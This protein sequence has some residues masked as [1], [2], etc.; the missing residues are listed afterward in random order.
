MNHLLPKISR[1]ENAIEKY[2]VDSDGL[3]YSFLDKATLK[4]PTEELF[5]DADQAENLPGFTLSELYC[6]ENVGMCTGG[7]ILGQLCHYEVTGTPTALERA[8][9]GFYGLY[10]VFR[11]GEQLEFGFFPKIYG[12][13]FSPETST[14]QVLYALYAMDKFHDFAT[15]EERQMIRMMIPAMVDFWVKRDYRYHYFHYHG[16]DW[17][18]P[19]ARFPALLLLAWKYSGDGKFRREYLRLLE[20]SRV[21][22]HADLYCKLNG[23]IPPNDYEK[24]HR[25]WLTAHCADRVT[26]DTMNFDVLLRNDPE[27]PLAECWRQGIKI[28]WQEALSTLAPNG[29]YYSMVLT[30]MDSRKTSRTPGYAVD[31]TDIHGAQSGWST[32]VVR[33]GVMA[34]YYFPDERTIVPAV[35]TVLDRLDFMDFTYYDEPERFPPGKRYQTRL[36]SGDATVNYLWC[37][38]LYSRFRH[39][40]EAVSSHQN[41][42]CFHDGHI[43]KDQRKEGNAKRSGPTGKGPGV[44]RLMKTAG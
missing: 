1:L 27:S 11:L 23:R 30:D 4:P 20:H 26:M 5:A 32:M 40:A 25:A 33:A 44:V 31:G 21:P 39:S 7:Y 42:Y 35:E 37:Y 19:S 12:G 22:E 9:R 2:F 29:K 36:L 16:N 13:H 43:A 14:D 41:R 18:W 6:Y 3:I 24:R 10:H 38:W 8:R 34:Q 15:A 28:M 17:Q